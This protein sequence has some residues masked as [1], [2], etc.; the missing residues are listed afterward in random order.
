MTAGSSIRNF[1]WALKPK[2][3]H[4]S[5]S[6]GSKDYEAKK[7][8]LLLLRK[9]KDNVNG[10]GGG[11]GRR[12]S[13]SGLTGSNLEVIAPVTADVEFKYT[14]PIEGFLNQVKSGGGGSNSTNSS[15]FGSSNSIGSSSSGN[16][17][18]GNGLDSKPFDI[19]INGVQTSWNLSI[20]FWTGEDGERLANPFVLCLNLLSCQVEAKKAAA[21]KAGVRFCF[22]ILNQI[23][24]EHE[25]GQPDNRAKDLVL[26]NTSEIKSVG[27]KNMA[28]SEK[29]MTS[30]G[31]IQLVCKLKLVKDD[32]DNHSL[33][34]DLR[35]LINDEKSADM[36]VE[37]GDGKEFK[38]HRNILSARSP[39][40]A[41]AITKLDD[42]QNGA[43]QTKNPD[44]AANSSS[45]NNNTQHKQQTQQQQQENQQKEQQEEENHQT[46]TN[47][48]SSTET[49]SSGQTVST[50]AST[51]TSST[52][53]TSSSTME[54][55]SKGTSTSCPST[56]KPK[57]NKLKIKD[58]QADTLEELL[59]YIYTDSSANVD[60]CANSLLAAAD[61]YQ[62]PGL[63]SHC[64][65]HLSEVITPV[66]VAAV[67]MLADQYACE[68]LKSSALKYC[69][70][71]HNYIVKDHAWKTIE[72]EKPGLF[73]EAVTRVVGDESSVCK[74]HS[75]CIK[76]KGKRYEIE[77][78]SS[79]I[80]SAKHLS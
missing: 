24:E 27:Y 3:R 29:H 38:V 34:S 53:S 6:G 15:M 44:A 16:G 76:K 39:V 4:R 28:I 75:E 23:S 41:S 58:L 21:T 74:E 68:R 19:N 46:L 54:N 66:N 35:N 14:W 1:T 32:S 61:L 72:E 22:G 64:E 59:S 2:K 31:D 13:A 17:S 73:E 60:A 50:S 65:Q 20:R 33:S 69:K 52:K 67:L 57:L 80:I 43:G 78:A 45:S 9:H 55:S 26:E 62:L 48:A 25:M 10:V 11:G 40:L 47:N 70:D 30:H 8:S 79:V 37:A 56:I 36:I 42:H 77:K 63:K 51:Q 12:L 71:N 5:G 7:K 18:N 49:P